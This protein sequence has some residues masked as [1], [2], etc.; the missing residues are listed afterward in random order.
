MTWR[1]SLLALA[2]LASLGVNIGLATHLGDKWREGRNQ[3][4]N[5]E[6]LRGDARVPMRD[7][8]TGSCREGNFTLREGAVEAYLAEVNASLSLT[9]EQLDLSGALLLH[10]A[11]QGCDVRTRRGTVRE[12]MKSR[13]LRQPETARAFISA[14][15]DLRDGL[16]DAAQKQGAL[17]RQLLESLSD[18]QLRSLNPRLLSR[19]LPGL[20]LGSASRRDQQRGNQQASP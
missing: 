13:P 17:Q 6:A 12:Q 2:L 20:D 1:T 16:T 14:M 3:Q 15:L 18:G 19:L 11:K 9:Q 5:S 7:F 10:R 4:A 8:V